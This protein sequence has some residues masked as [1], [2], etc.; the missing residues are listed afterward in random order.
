M[1]WNRSTE[2]E[3][4]RGNRERETGKFPFRGLVAGVI[5]VL[6][7]AVAAWWLWPTGES[8]GETP[9]P[10]TK[11]RIKEVTPAAVAKP[12][13]ESEKAAPKPKTFAEMTNEEK[14]ADIRAKYGNNIPENLKPIV[15]Y[16]EHP[17]QRDF[18]AP[19]RP[20]AI[21]K[22][23]SERMIAEML[24]VEPGNFM[25]RKPTFDAGFDADFAAA[26]NEK[27]EFDK[28]DT[29]YQRELKQAVIDSKAEIAERMRKGET[30][31]EIMNKFSDELF[32]LS[33]YQQNIEQ[34]VREVKMNPKMTDADVKDC[35][36]AANEMLASKGIKPMAMPN[37]VFRQAAL[38]FQAEKMKKGSEK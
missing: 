16:L 19:P 5:V 38:R 28:D 27:I 14:L 32:E 35:V 7:A 17:P 23:H 26:L 25:L 31:S 22:R 30:A 12:S 1:A 37:M 15:R 6:G 11:Q 20:T 10:Q 18:R 33:R 8:A 29:D 3:L 36:N 24:L 21:F 34:M 9:P 2:R 4:G 13:A